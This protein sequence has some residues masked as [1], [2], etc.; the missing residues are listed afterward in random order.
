MIDQMQTLLLQNQR[1]QEHPRP[2][3][4][5]SIMEAAKRIGR[6]DRAWVDALPDQF[7]KDDAMEIWG[8]CYGHAKKVLQLLR[9][10]GLVKYDKEMG[11]W[12]KL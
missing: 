11:M 1:P 6:Q 8:Y 5:I 4:R 7:T 10:S 2:L 3:R 12:T 9:A